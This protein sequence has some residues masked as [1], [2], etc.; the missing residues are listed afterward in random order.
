MSLNV[1]QEA[2]QALR[3]ANSKVRELH[4]ELL[5]QAKSLVLTYGDN[6][7][8]LGQHDSSIENLLSQLVDTSGDEVEV[9]K[10]VKKLTLSAN[11]I[12]DHIEHDLYKGRS[13]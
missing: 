1:S 13:R 9:K 11:L 12:A 10:L 6:K 8:G 5:K 7:D 2:I 4:I 3:A